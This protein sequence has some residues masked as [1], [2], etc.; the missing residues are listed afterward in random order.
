MSLDLRID[1][2]EG[3]VPES[4]LRLIGGLEDRTML[5]EQIAT[6]VHL[7]VKGHTQMLADTR[8]KTADELG[9]D[10][11]DFWT[12]TVERISRSSSKE[13]ATVSIQNPGIGRAMHPVKI[14]PTDGHDFLTIPVHPLAYGHRASELKRELDTF[15]VKVHDQLVIGYKTPGQKVMTTL[16]LLLPEIDLPQDRTLLPSD[17]EFEE[18]VLGKPGAEEGDSALGRYITLLLEAKAVA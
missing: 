16:Y 7:L 18:T 15:V 14:L 13:G 17:E 3:S 11:T 9:A 12:D 6:D 4:V 5:H 8:H 10:P 1:I 2:D